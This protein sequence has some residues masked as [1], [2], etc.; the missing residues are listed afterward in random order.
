MFSVTTSRRWAE[1]S[2]KRWKIL[3]RV[4]AMPRDKAEAVQAWLDWAARWADS[5]DPRIR[6]SIARSSFMTRLGGCGQFEIECLVAR[7]RNTP[8]DSKVAT[9]CGSPAALAQAGTLFRH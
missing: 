4:D 1:S 5:I 2:S 7:S 9:T 6:C 8:P 3:R